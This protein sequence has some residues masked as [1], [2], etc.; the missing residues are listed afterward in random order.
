VDILNII[1]YNDNM[2]NNIIC[3]GDKFGE[4]TV[5]EILK[6]RTNNRYIQCLCECSC[7]VTKP[8]LARSL[9]E[10]RSK[11]CGHNRAERIAKLNTA[12][13]TKHGLSKTHEYFSYQKMIERCYKPTT[14]CYR[15]Y[16]GR[17]ITVC[18]QWRGVNGFLQFIQDVGNRPQDDYSLDRINNNGNYEPCNVRWASKTT[19]LINRRHVGRL[20]DFSDK[21]I[22]DECLKRSDVNASFTIGLRH[23]GI[24]RLPEARDSV[25]GNTDI[26]KEAPVLRTQTLEPLCL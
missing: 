19:Q 5:I 20:S 7:G 12:G 18:D 23:Q 26:P 25:K 13:K 22:I 11:C 21:E 16:G 24:L 10:G 15:H 14:K 1:L 17:G 3:I 8:V 6:E 9:R 4:W 2:K